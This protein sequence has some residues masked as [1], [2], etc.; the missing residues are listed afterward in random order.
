[1]FFPP[2]NKLSPIDTFPWPRKYS[3]QANVFPF[4]PKFF[5][6][7]IFLKRGSPDEVFL[8]AFFPQREFLAVS[9]FANLPR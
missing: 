1:M 7:Q 4:H 8:K 9:L 5:F 2:I 3:F 6:L